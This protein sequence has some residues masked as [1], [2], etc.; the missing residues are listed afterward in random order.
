M[1][2]NDGNTVE[3]IIIAS[4]EYAVGKDLFYCDDI[5]LEVGWI[6]NENGIFV[7]PAPELPEPVEIPIPELTQTEIDAILAELQNAI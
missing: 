3:N 5:N 1:L 2:S 4:E 6:K 7:D